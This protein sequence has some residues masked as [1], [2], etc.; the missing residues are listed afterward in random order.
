MKV[1]LSKCAAAA[2]MTVVLAAPGQA[3]E[4]AEADLAR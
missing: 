4:F 1:T 2:L 3:D